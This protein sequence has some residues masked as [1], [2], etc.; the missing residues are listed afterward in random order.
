MTPKRVE[1]RAT[2]RQMASAKAGASFFAS[3]HPLRSF[4]EAIVP[5]FVCG[6]VVAMA[7]AV[8]YKRH[9][10]AANYQGEE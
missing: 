2:L 1:V 5:E 9:E 8:E 4:S 3:C 7:A 10:P 6:F